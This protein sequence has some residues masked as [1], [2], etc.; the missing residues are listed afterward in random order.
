MV[1]SAYCKQQIVQLYF[2]R[3]LSYAN[4]A[5]FLAA[6]RYNYR[7][8]STVWATIKKYKM[9]GTLSRLPGSGRR[10]KLMPDILAIIE[11]QMRVDDETTATQLVKIVNAV[12]YNISKS[13]I[14]RA[15]RI[16]V[17]Y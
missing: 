9:N 11:E 2:E 7:F 14:V 4:V 16:L 13:T 17:N 5:K 6:E 8:N 12:G 1:L 15:R 10:F 3:R